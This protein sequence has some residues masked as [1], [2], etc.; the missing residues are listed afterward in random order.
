MVYVLTLQG[1][2]GLLNGLGAQHLLH[3]GITFGKDFHLVLTEVLKGCLYN[4][5][6][7]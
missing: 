5:N 1:L 6:S 2:I 7:L 3:F 4:C